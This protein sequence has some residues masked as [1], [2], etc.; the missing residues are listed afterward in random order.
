VKI[1]FSIPRLLV[2][3]YLRY[4]GRIQKS[5]F[6][7]MKAVGSLAHPAINITRVYASAKEQ[8]MGDPMT[9]PFYHFPQF[10]FIQRLL[11]RPIL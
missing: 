7:R 2:D 1:E 10:R 11:G 8:L 6:R 4:S 9:V 3:D 5:L